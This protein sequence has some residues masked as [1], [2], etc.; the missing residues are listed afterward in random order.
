MKCVFVTE[1]KKF[2][3]PGYAKQL[4]KFAG[5]HDDD[6]MVLDHSAIFRRLY[7][8]QQSF[9]LNQYSSAYQVELYSTIAR[10]CG[11][12]VE[13]NSVD[14]IYLS[15]T[16]LGAQRTYGEETVQHIFEKN[17][18]RIIYPETMSVADQVAC[19]KNCKI[20]AG[21]AGTALHLAAFMKPGGTVIQIKRNSSVDDSSFPQNLIN[22]TNKLNFVTIWGSVEARP[23][24]HNTNIPQIIGVTP[25]MRKFFDDYGFDYNEND[26]TH[27]PEIL[28]AYDR[29]MGLYRAR[30]KYTKLK[31]SVAKIL[32][33]FIPGR[34]RRHDVYECV[35]RF[36][37]TYDL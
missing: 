16:K 1:D 33:R 3:M 20:L 27:A 29:A 10:I 24:K 25:Y 23:S 13:K 12:G 26:L 30:T 7:I 2:V 32:S 28:E 14:K 21:C 22:Q 15:R 34:K 9:H 6:I 17:G 18:F 5:L 4:L 11:G 31:K 37:K 35:K 19:V 8:P 36:L